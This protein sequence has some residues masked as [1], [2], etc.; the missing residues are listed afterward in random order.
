MA[1]LDTTGRRLPR[2]RAAKTDAR[3]IPGHLAIGSPGFLWSFSQ[4]II[5]VRAPVTSAMP[6]VATSAPPLRDHA[7]GERDEEEVLGDGDAELPA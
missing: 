7:D 6:T 4:V 2:G 1:A 3:I 5:A